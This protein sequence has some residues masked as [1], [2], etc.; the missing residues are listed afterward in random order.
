[1]ADP[2]AP[3]ND[4]FGNPV[5]TRPPEVVAGPG[6]PGSPYAS[7][8]AR[9]N[10]LAVASLVMGILWMYGIGAILAL[11]F[12]YLA[13]GQISRSGGRET[14]RGL[15]IA[16]IVLGWIGV[17]GAILIIVM[18]AVVLSREGFPDFNQ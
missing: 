14:G 9:T 7:P 13:K 4:P 15:A 12:G 3:P 2:F 10:G 18:F 1:V 16:G 5:P 8:V 6:P 17:A 11:V